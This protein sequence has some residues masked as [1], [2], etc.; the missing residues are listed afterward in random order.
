MDQGEWKRQFDNAVHR[1]TELLAEGARESRADPLGS[2]VAIEVSITL[3]GT[4]VTF[5]KCDGKYVDSLL[6]SELPK[7]KNKLAVAHMILKNLY[8]KLYEGLA[9]SIG[10]RIYDDLMVKVYNEELA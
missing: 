7:D 10:R 4:P 8:Y 5:Y 3:N 1:L 9:E 6:F 2:R